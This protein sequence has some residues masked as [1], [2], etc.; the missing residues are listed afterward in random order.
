[1]IIALMLLNIA[2][3]AND[4]PVPIAG[5]WEGESKCM[6][7]GSPCHDEHVIYEIKTDS[8]A[9]GRYK[10]DAYKVISGERQF[11]GTLDCSYPVQNGILRCVGRRP[12]DVWT[13]TVAADQMTGTLVVGT[14]RQL[15]RRVQITR[16]QPH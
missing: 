14:D 11:M 15:F 6:V 7:A 2:S 9:A 10:V 8:Q 12:D 3:T 13:F 16:S 5:T 4:K 1:M